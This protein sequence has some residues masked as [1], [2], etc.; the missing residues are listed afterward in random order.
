M[1]YAT[2]DSTGSFDFGFPYHEQRMRLVI[3]QAP[4][5][6]L[7]VLIELEAGQ[8]ICDLSNGCPIKV[9]FDNGAPM[10]FT[11]REPADYSSN[12][13]FLSPEQ[14]FVA[15][16]KKST[17]AVVEATFYQHGQVQYEFSTSGLVWK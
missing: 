12:S 11:G 7:S 4:S 3:R 17:H 2:L 6:G 14:R 1:I 5:D 9:K 13:L 10:T 8:F 16:L 15:A